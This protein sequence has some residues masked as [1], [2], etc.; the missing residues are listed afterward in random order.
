MKTFRI[1]IVLVIIAAA[2]F[3]II[4]KPV[5]HDVPSDAAGGTMLEGTD[6]YCYLWS[7]PA[8]DRAT[9]DL[10]V[11]PGGA[12]SGSF[13]WVPAQKDSKRGS[14]EGVAYATDEEG[15]KRVMKGWWHTSAEGT[16]A[17]E[18][19]SIRFDDKTAAAGFGEMKDRGD[20][21]FVYANSTNL[22]YAPTLSR[23]DCEGD[24]VR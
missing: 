8:G 10:S 4:K 6:H 18:E 12:T 20:G 16:T 17:T 7:T 14:F 19:L 13:E 24:A 11:V 22:S 9:I 15:I 21:T 5:P 23:I 1:F 2:L 3:L